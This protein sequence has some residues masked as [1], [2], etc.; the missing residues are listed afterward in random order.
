MSNFLY[1]LFVCGG[2]GWVWGDVGVG[3]WGCVGVCV[4]GVCVCV[5]VCVC[6]SFF[7]KKERKKRKK[8]KT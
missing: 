7:L 2:M 6:V 8:K 3:A 5:W 4:G 1:C